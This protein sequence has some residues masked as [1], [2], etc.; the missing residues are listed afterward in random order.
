MALPADTNE[1]IRVP[2]LFRRWE[3]EQVIDAGTDFHIE[4][5]GTTSDGTPLL[6]LYRREPTTSDL[7]GDPHVTHCVR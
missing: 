2:G 1:F 4:D 7:K 3:I 5:A 6:A